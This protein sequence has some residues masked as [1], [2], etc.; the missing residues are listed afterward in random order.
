MHLGN[1]RVAWVACPIDLSGFA[2]SIPL[3]NFL[4]AHHGEEVVLLVGER[5]FGV[6][7]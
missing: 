2:F 3:V 7:A 6:E 1:E 5:D 4:D